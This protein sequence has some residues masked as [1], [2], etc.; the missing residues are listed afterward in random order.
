MK[1]T[2]ALIGIVIVWRTLMERLWPINGS[3]RT[4]PLAALE[5]EAARLTVRW[6][7]TDLQFPPQPSGPGERHR[8]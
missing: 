7:K 6:L 4:M 2:L 5:R 8:G 3:A 1:I